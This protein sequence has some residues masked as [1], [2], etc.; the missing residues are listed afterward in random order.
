[1]LFS[2]QCHTSRCPKCNAYLGTAGALL[3]N[4]V[5]ISVHE[6]VVGTAIQTL[7]LTDHAPDVVCANCKTPIEVDPVEE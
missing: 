6:G 2:F 7:K 4:G 3:V 1:M 5:A